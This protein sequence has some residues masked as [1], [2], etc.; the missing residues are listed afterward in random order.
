MS[1]TKLKTLINISSHFSFRFN[2]KPKFPYVSFFGVNKCE[3]DKSL[4]LARWFIYRLPSYSA[5]T[6][7][8]NSLYYVFLHIF[9]YYPPI[10]SFLTS[11]KAEEAAKNVALL[12]FLYLMPWWPI[13]TETQNLWNEPQLNCELHLML[14]WLSFC[15]KPGLQVPRPS[16]GKTELELRVNPL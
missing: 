12:E 3:K 6:H 13:F 7:I 8:L 9:H 14:L 16:V 4:Y 11:K 5:V 10:C 1:H 2:K 15:M